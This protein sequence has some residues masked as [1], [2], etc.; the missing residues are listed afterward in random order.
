MRV[1]AVVR[2]AVVVGG[3]LAAGDDQRAVQQIALLAREERE[4]HRM[5]AGRGQR[6]QQ[7]R[8]GDDIVAG[9]GA[10]RGGGF[11]AAAGHLELGV[12]HRLVGL[13][14]VDQ[15]RQLGALALCDQLE[16]LRPAPPAAL[17][18]AR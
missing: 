16:S 15:Y 10:E 18:P 3:R 1:F 9:L 17:L 6:L 5:L 4:H 8:I 7:C 2:V 13:L 12:Q 14:A 11:D